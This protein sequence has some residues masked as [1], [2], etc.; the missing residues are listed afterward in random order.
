MTFGIER[1]LTDLKGLG[2]S[3]VRQVTAGG[4]HYA[5][6]PDFQI[7][8]GSFH[9]RT[10]GLGIPSTGDYPRSVSASIHVNANPVL[11]ATSIPGK[12]NIQASGLGG[13]W[14]YWSFQFKLSPQN[15]TSEL[16]D[17]INEIFRKC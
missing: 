10:I 13:A 3:T 1:L 14:Q 5:I 16:M 7:S 15:P 11:Y 4:I 17:K 12:V 8:G 9:D 2:Y 6:I